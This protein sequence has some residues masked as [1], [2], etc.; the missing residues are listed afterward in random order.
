[1]NARSPAP[2]GLALVEALVNTLDLESGADR[3][4]T[5]E[6]RAAF[7]LAEVP[8]EEELAQAHGKLTTLK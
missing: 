5:A 8:A 2:G 4:D 6:G 1:M 7:G 3:L